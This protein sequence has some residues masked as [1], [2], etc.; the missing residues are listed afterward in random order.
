MQ[1]QNKTEYDLHTVMAVCARSRRTIRRTKVRRIDTMQIRKA[2]TFLFV[3]FL[4]VALVGLV[5]EFLF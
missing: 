2:V 4:T 5:R 1:R 3:L